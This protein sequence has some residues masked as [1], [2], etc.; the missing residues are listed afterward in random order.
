VSDRRGFHHRRLPPHSALL[1]G[2]EVP[3]D[4]A[5]RSQ[6]LQV[7]FNDR[8]AEP[9][10]DPGA[11]FHRESDEMFVVLEGALLVAVD[12][13]TVRVGAGEFCCFSAGLVHELVSIETPLRTLMIRAPSVDD[14]VYPAGGGSPEPRAAPP[15]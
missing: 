12:G 15:R 7:W 6:S 4:L 2:R 10:A 14:K 11:H 8:P 3:D 5:F 1:S 9:W 13:E